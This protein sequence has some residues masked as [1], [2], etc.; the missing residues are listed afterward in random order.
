[1]KKKPVILVVDDEKWVRVSLGSLLKESG[2][3]VDTA[4]DGNEAKRKIE[5]G[6]CDMIIT[7]LKMR[8]ISGLD[9][10]KFAKNHSC[11]SEVLILTAYGTVESAVEAIKLGA[12]DYLT[13]PLDI[14]GSAGSRKAGTS[15]RSLQP[16]HADA[17]KVWQQKHHLFKPQNEKDTGAR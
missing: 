9:I 16:S 12:F 1:M 3:T 6:T 17:A 5:S 8:D 15:R 2:Y 13:K 10:L 14:D 4:A 7:D 11:D